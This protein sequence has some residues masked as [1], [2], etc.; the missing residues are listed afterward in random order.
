[1]RIVH[2]NAFLG[3]ERFMTGDNAA[4]LLNGPA[5]TQLS[6]PRSRPTNRRHRR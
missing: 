6:S 2:R 5:I 4:Q 1:M 3:P